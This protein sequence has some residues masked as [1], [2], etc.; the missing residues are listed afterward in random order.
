MINEFD[1]DND[2]TKNF[3]IHRETMQTISICDVVKVYD[4]IN[5][6]SRFIPQENDVLDDIESIQRPLLEI[7]NKLRSERECPHCGGLLFLSDLPQYDFVCPL[8]DENF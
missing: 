4:Y 6:I 1:N 2:R 3:C 7:I 5:L 8:C